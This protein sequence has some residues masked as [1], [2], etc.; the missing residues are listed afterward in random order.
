M[1][2]TGLAK[3]MIAT[4]LEKAGIDGNRRGETF[5]LEEF[6]RIANAWSTLEEK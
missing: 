3:E 1:K 4:I 6:A 5:T 2:T